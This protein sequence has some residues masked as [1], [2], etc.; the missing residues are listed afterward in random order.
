MRHFEF[1]DKVNDSAIVAAIAAAEKRTTG[2]IR[3]FISRRKWPV[4]KEGAEKHFATLGM[5]KTKHRNGV[6][7]FV[8]PR[9]RTF[10]IWGDVGIHKHCGEAFWKSVRDEMEGHLKEGR[11]TEAL[12]HA[13]ERTGGL[14]AEHFPCE[15]GENPNEQGDAVVRD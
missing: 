14:L 4:A 12:V 6:L 3:V 15:G 2:E 9:S 13:V 8:A 5:S 1:L 7:I 11:Y 10:A